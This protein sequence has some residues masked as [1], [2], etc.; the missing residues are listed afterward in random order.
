[1]PSGFHPTRYFL[2]D[3]SIPGVRSIVY[4]RKKGKV[5]S[6][7]YVLNSNRLFVSISFLVKDVISQAWKRPP[8]CLHSVYLATLNN[9]VLIVK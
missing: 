4:T 2:K 1:M 7:F 6:K 9:K 8:R 5:V 3:S